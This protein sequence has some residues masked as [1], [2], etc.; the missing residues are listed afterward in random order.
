[1]N[2]SNESL[3]VICRPREAKQMAALFRECTFYFPE[4]FINGIYAGI[5]SSDVVG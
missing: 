5:K 3:F 1:M 4:A 2:I